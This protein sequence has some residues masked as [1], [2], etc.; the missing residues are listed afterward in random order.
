MQGTMYK[1]MMVAALTALSMVG[2][3]SGKED[4]GGNACDLYVDAICECQPA[5]CDDLRRTYEGA[6]PDVQEDC[7]QALKNWDQKEFVCDGE[8]D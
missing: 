7:A 5:N 8:E 3:G 6:H 1:T 4:T 2:C